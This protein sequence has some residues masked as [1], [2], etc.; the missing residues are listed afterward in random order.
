MTAVRLPLAILILVG[1]VLWL[2]WLVDGVGK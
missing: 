1:L 2:C